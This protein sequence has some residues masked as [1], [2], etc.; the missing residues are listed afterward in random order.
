VKD[1]ISREEFEA[2]QDEDPAST[3]FD[4][5]TASCDACGEENVGMGVPVMMAIP[6]MLFPSREFDAPVFVAD[7]DVKLQIITLPNGMLGF[8]TD[9]TKTKYLHEEC[10]QLSL[11]NLAYEV[12]E[13]EEEEDEEEEDEE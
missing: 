1:K 6:G 12:E 7:P 5:I 13:D 2:Q 3:S 10:Y 8:F 11:D 4:D 9:E